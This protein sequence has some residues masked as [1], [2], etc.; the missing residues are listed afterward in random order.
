MTVGSTIDSLKG[1]RLFVERETGHLF[2]GLFESFVQV[3]ET[4]IVLEH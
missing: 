1:K 4:C 3:V 2:D